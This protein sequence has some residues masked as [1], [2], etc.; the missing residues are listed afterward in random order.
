[1]KTGSRSR[2]TR[3][4]DCWMTTQ[5]LG[6]SASFW[7]GCSANSSLCRFKLPPR[8]IRSSRLLKSLE[9]P[10]ILLSDEMLNVAADHRFHVAIAK[11]S[12]N[13]LVALVLEPIVDLLHEQRKRLFSLE[14][15]PTA[16]QDFPHKIL[17]AIERRNARNAFATMR[18][19]LEQVTRDINRLPRQ[20]RRA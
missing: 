5:L 12:G 8:P 7:T 1:M 2:F 20:R 13:P 6:R 19:H 3:L 4:S 15:S 10:R 17:A 14:N 16:A 18:A 11:A 9:S